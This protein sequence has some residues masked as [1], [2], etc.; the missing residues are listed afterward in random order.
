MPLTLQEHRELSREMMQTTRRLHAM[1]DLVVSVYGPQ[2]PAAFSF[3]RTMEAFD[4]LNQ[5]MQT[6]AVRDLPGYPTNDLY[7]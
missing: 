6:Q 5:E 7:V 1:C 4:R 3:L 2:S